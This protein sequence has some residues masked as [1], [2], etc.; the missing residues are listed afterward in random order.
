MIR[1]VASQMA[2]MNGVEKTA[3]S[4]RM[5]LASIPAVNTGGLRP[6]AF[7]PLASLGVRGASLGGLRPPKT[8]RE[9]AYG[10]GPRYARQGPSPTAT[11]PGHRLPTTLAIDAARW[12]GG[13]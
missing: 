1:P 9:T 3:G 13:R 10:L 5:V 8:P 2:V 12:R 11:G 4:G 7:T 6:P